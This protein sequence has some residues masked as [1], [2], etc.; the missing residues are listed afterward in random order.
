MTEREHR[1]EQKRKELF[2]SIPQ[3]WPDLYG[4]E[5]ALLD[6]YPLREDELNDIRIAT[7]RVGKIYAKTAKILRRSD[8]ETLM[9]LDFPKEVIPFIRQRILP[10]ESVIARCD[11]IMT[12]EGLKLI[13]LNSDTPTFIKECFHVNQKVTDYFDVENPNAG[14]E[15]M[16]KRSVEKAIKESIVKLKLTEP[17]IV[18]TSHDDHIEDK[19]TTQYLQEL[20]SFPSTYVP[21]HELSIRKGEG[22][23]DHHG[24]KIDVLYR[25]TYPLE[26]LL[27]DEDP[28][29]KEK[30]GIQLLEL[31]Q[32]GRLAI[33][34]PISAFLLQ[35]KAV[36]AVIWGLHEQHHHFFTETEH[37]WI[38][39]YFLPTYLDDTPF[40]EKGIPYVKKP[41]FGR[42]GDTVEIYEGR[43]IRL[44]DS[45]KTYKD[46]LPVYQSYVPLP[47]KL[48]QTTNG[49]QECHLLVGSFLINAEPSAIGF[50]AGGP[51]TDNAAYFLPVGVVNS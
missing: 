5:Y 1:F 34:N 19:W 20:V 4:E 25:Q 33:I 14:C 23:Y 45:H 48:L 28:I 13:E 32:T 46:S 10:V 40:L 21:L 6:Y 3:F 7:E 12:D 47:K 44:G 26:H 11:F 36:Q 17:N 9:Q 42:E 43:K 51:I 8:D 37:Q 35:S 22:L 29:T 41:S 16:L 2:Q 30:V 38:H 15:S 39:T 50:R 18:F 31:V 27:L 49:K 24:R